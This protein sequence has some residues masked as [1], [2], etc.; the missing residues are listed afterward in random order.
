M[1]ESLIFAFGI[2]I[3]LG[4]MLFSYMNLWIFIG[5]VSF[6]LGCLGLYYEFKE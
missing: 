6:I 3:G 4:L 5:A 1:F 2:V